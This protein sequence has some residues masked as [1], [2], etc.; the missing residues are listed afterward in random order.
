MNSKLIRDIAWNMNRNSICFRD[1]FQLCVFFIE[2]IEFV[3][4]V[5][6][7]INKQF[8]SYQFNII[9]VI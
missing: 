6:L 3:H 8:D 9:L 7:L 1:F 2:N 4:I 5:L